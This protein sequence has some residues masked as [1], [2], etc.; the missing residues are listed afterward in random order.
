MDMVGGP[1]ATG[2]LCA[3]SWVLSPVCL[4]YKEFGLGPSLMVLF[5]HLC[6]TFRLFVN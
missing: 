2:G 3:A 5:S 6:P 1:R 4:V